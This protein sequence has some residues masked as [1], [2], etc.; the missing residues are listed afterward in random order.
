MHSRFGSHRQPAW[1]WAWPCTKVSIVLYCSIARL[2]CYC[3][4]LVV[5]ESMN[6]C[7]VS[8]R[9]TQYCLCTLFMH[10]LN[11]HYYCL[12]FARRSLAG[13]KPVC[14][15]HPRPLTT[16]PGHNN[17]IDHHHHHHIIITRGIYPYLPMAPSAPWSGH[18]YFFLGGSGDLLKV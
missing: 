10:M 4:P 7:N 11:V 1:R 6:F 3:S 2:R 12:S 5:Y 15:P 13:G 14:S 17:V 8:N 9:P 18:Y 16:P